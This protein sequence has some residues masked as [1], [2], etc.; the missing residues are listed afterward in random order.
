MRDT[1]AAALT[2]T[3]ACLYRSNARKAFTVRPAPSFL[4]STLA[5][6]ART[7]QETLALLWTK[8][9]VNSALTVRIAIS[10]P[11][12]KN[13]ALAWMATCAKKAVSTRLVLLARADRMSALNITTAW[14]AS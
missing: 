5:R 6:W 3:V 13:Q 8:I 14:V 7:I 11:Q 1:I 10:W 9:I 4:P 12:P 2:P